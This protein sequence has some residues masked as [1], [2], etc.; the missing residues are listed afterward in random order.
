M[1]KEIRGVALEKRR[2]HKISLGSLVLHWQLQPT[3]AI[4]SI[5]H[6]SH[7][8]HVTMDAHLKTLKV[9]EL[10]AVLAAAAVQV[11]ARATKADLIAKIIAEPA[12]VAAYKKAHAPEEVE[13]EVEE[14][15]EEVAEEPADEPV[16][17]AVVEATPEVPD[18]A[19]PAVNEEEEK[20]R[21]RAERFGIPVVAPAAPKT[22]TRAPKR[23]AEESVDPEELEKRRK[24][25]ER[26]GIPVRPPRVARA[27]LTVP[28]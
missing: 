26:F 27:S 23:A 18:A 16:A 13:E 17:E 1:R 7:M 10:K 5:S 3:T 22:R 19:A 11:P 15:V 24:R 12:A 20:R 21:K 28:R 2:K 4:G 9:P 14:V 8:S 6:Q 25:A